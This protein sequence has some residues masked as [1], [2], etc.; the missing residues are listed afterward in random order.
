MFA[1]QVSMSLAYPAL[2]NP[3]FEQVLMFSQEALT[4]V[5]NQLVLFCAESLTDK[6]TSLLEV[7]SQSL[8]DDLGSAINGS[9]ISRRGL[10]KIDQSFGQG[11]D[12]D[13]RHLVGGD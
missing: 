10:V 5:L 8:P 13:F 2:A 12:S 11:V 9:L 4:K 6:G 3:F 1:P 7:V